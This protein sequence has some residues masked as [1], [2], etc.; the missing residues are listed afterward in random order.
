[1]NQIFDNANQWLN[2]LVSYVP[3]KPIEDVARELGL[4]PDK[5]VKLAS[6][7]NPLGPSPM[8]VKAMQEALQKAH[9]YPD[10]GGY[11]LRAGIAAKYGVG[12]DHVILGTGSNE[13]IEFLGHAFLRPDD[14]IVTAEHAFVVYKILAKLFGAETIEVPDP[15]LTHDLPA[16]AAA[17]NDRT[18]IVYIANPN[19]PTGTMVSEAELDRLVDRVQRNVVIALDEAYYEFLPDPPNTLK[20][21]RNHPNVIVLRTFSKIQGLAGLRIGY[22]L[23][24]EDLIRL[25][26]KTRQPF[27]V[28]S[29]AQ[30]GALAGLRDDA[31][32]AKTREVVRQGRDFLQAEFRKRNLEYVPSVAN[33]ILVNVGNGK[34]VFQKLLRRG[35]IVRAMDEY[36][37]PEWIRVTVGTPVQNQRFLEDLDQVLTEDYTDKT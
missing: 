2:D 33:F 7:E 20:Y 6:N 17:I 12:I 11:H 5:I 21:F 22:G 24:H 15:N 9:Y 31:Y 13:I 23:A 16:M 4:D 1:M 10:G 28:N 8:A 37:L 29:I 30:A 35:M 27:N 14:N 34:E 32:Q 3:G 19:N 18:K 36:K 25:L 26:Q